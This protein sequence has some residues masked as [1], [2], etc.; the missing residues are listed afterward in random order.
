LCRELNGDERK[1]KSRMEAGPGNRRGGKT[2]ADRQGERFK[3]I[4]K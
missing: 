3:E 1:N 2:T 4:V